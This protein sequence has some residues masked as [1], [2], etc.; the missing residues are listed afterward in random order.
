MAQE[1]A[2]RKDEFF[3]VGVDGA[4]EAT[5]AMA[6]EGSTIAATSAQSPSNMIKKSC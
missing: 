2:N 6:K 4:P 5:E 3:I 1:Q